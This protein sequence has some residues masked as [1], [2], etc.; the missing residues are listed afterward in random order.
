MGRTLEEWQGQIGTVA[1]D[2]GVDLSPQQITAVGLL[3]AIN[4]FSIDRPRDLVVEQ[5]G[6]GSAYLALPSGWVPG[7]SRISWIEYP[8]RQNPPRMIDD[9][10]WQLTRSPTDVTVER[11][12]LLEAVPAASEWVRF[13]FTAPWP[14]PTASASVDQVDDVAFHAVTALA[15]SYCLTHL[16]AET[17]RSRSG[18]LP[19]NF[20][21]GSQ[22]TRDLRDVAKELRSVYDR[23]LGRVSTMDPSNTGPGPVSK[24]FDFD[25]SYL[26][27]FHGRR[28]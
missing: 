19:T 22:R 11:I 12:L 10:A 20:V 5:A 24:P 6:T 4:L 25:P 2:A 7:F 15:A 3:P 17:A 27:L 16:A 18:A 21:D 9:Q 28:R 14:T 23:F 8:A 1:R 26:T 13:G